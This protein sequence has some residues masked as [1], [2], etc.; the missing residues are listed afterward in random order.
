M[1]PFNGFKLVPPVLVPA[2]RSMFA[3]QGIDG[4]AVSN[5]GEIDPMALLA[6]G[7]DRLEVRTAFSPPIVIDLKGP[8]SPEARAAGERIKPTV[9]FSGRAGRAEI[10][11]YGVPSGISPEVKQAGV[12]IG[13][14]LGAALLGILLFGGA[15]FRR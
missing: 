3:S 9:I 2:V 7:F 6:L 8:P 12:S 1:Q 4:S 14:G 10:A 15:V 5:T 13:L 11:P